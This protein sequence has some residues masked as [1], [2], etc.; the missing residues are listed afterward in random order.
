MDLV[1]PGRAAH[2]TALN[3]RGRP[4]VSREVAL[5]YCQ[6]DG[7]QQQLQASC[8]TETRSRQAA[9]TATTDG[10]TT[11]ADGTVSTAPRTLDASCVYPRREFV[12]N[13]CPPSRNKAL[14]REAN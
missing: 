8:Q 12:S 9:S 13:A 6:N 10:R 2:I 5:V 7:E 3:H 4:D 14:C 1:T 11:A